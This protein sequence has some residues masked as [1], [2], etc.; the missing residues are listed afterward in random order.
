MR[1]REDA[2]NNEEVVE[3]EPQIEQARGTERGSGREVDGT[4][5]SPKTSIRQRT[6]TTPPSSTRCSART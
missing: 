5:S 1:W 6:K 4:G 2:E 3:R